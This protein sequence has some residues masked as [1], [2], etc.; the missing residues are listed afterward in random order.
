MIVVK[1]KNVNKDD[2]ISNKMR[3]Q[4]KKLVKGITI[5]NY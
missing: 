3:G 5:N 4:M 1:P 2:K